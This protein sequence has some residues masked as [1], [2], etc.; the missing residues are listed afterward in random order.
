MIVVWGVRVGMRR[1][2]GVL[3]SCEVLWRV[4]Q[5]ARDGFVRGCNEDTEDWAES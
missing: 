4:R 2:E 3:F 5:M 1:G